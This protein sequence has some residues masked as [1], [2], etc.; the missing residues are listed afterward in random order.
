MLA[1][2]HYFDQGVREVWCIAEVNNSRVRGGKNPVANRNSIVE[3]NVNT[4]IRPIVGVT[5][6][7]R[8]AAPPNPFLFSTYVQE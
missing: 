7:I 1:Y 6:E 3:V 8:E 2:E 5:A 4:V